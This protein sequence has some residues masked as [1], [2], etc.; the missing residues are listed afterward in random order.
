MTLLN[1]DSDGIHNILILL[2]R[3]LLNGKKSET[4]LINSF[5]VDGMDGGK[6]RSTLGKWLKLG[7]FKKLEGGMIEIDVQQK[8]EKALK[9]KPEHAEAVIPSMV[10]EVVFREANNKNFWGN[11]DSGSSD[12]TRGLALLLAQDI[13]MTNPTSFEITK[14]AREQFKGSNVDV[15]QNSRDPGTITDFA[16]FLGFTSELNGTLIDPTIALI[17]DFKYSFE[18]DEEMSSKSFLDRLS[19]MCP[20]LDKGLYRISVEEKLN[21]EKWQKVDIGNKISTSLSFA[22][23]RLSTLKIIKLDLKDD[24]ASIHQLIG[25]KGQDPSMDQQATKFSRVIYQGESML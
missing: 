5:T 15:I 4:D 8:F 23:L 24:S 19:H 10:R 17:Q 18:K 2:I 9:L 25:S 3:Y 1:R 11:S 21:P 7:L 13:Y 12:L 6:L 14:L 22:I 20:V 16:K